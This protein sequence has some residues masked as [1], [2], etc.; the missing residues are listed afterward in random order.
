MSQST[1]MNPF[2]FIVGCP[3]SGTTLLQRML[4]SHPRIAITPESHWIPRLYVKPWALTPEGCVTSKLVRRLLAHRKLARLQLDGNNVRALVGNGERVTYSVLVARIF[5]QYGKAKGKPLV[6][7]KTPD[8]VRRIGTLHALWP[9]ASFVHV[10]RDGRDVAMSMLDWPKVCPKPGD[11]V[12]WKDDPIA[13][14]AWWW[15]LNVR[16]GREAGSSLGPGLYHEVRYE[17]LIA[18]PEEEMATL[19]DFLGVPYDAAMLRFHE[20]GTDPGLEQKYAGRPV[21]PGLRDWNTQMPAAKVEQFEGVAGN[22][23]EQLGYSRAVERPCPAAS[24]GAARVRELLA[25]DPR[26]RD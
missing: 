24:E 9:R 17:S 12:T 8:Y 1:E 19:C 2:V 25:R 26:P 5:D 16:F 14:A 23:L 6:G 7:D 10:I 11:F 21:T 13:T 22:L 15:E 4:N 18:R 20:V 3:R